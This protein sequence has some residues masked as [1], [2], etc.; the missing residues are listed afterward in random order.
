[1]LFSKKEPYTEIAPL[2]GE[3][4]DYNVYHE[5]VSQKA[6]WYICGF[7]AG[8]VVLYVFYNNIIASIILGVGCGFAAIPLL[9][10]RRLNKR[11]S[12]LTNQFKG[13]LETLATSIGAGRN[14]YDSFSAAGDDLAVQFAPD[15]DIVTETKIIRLGLDNNI[16]IEDLLMN[17]AL[18]SGIDDVKSFANVFATCYKKGGNIKEVVKNT[19]SIISDKIE[20]QMELETIVSGQKNEQNILLVMP[21]VFVFILRTMGGDLIDLTSAVGILSVTAAIVIFVLAYFL[22]KRILNIK[23]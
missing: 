11:K 7:L 17:F 22:S 8:G 20:V 1:M 5:S 4:D 10:E 19:A 12:A 2:I 14:I 16:S 9:R 6:L 3:A 21:V 23:F 13:L 15:A 18:R